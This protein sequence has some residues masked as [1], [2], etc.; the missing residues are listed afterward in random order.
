[1][2]NGSV[3]VTLAL[4]KEFK[5]SIRYNFTADDNNIENEFIEH[6][7][8]H[9]FGDITWYPSRHTAVYRYD[10]RVAISTPGDGVN[11]FIGFQSNLILVSKSDRA[12]GTFFFTYFSSFIYVHTTLYSCMYI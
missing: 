6:G 8:K 4:E 7:K 3:Q 1:M 12:A 2:N 10:D 5:R 9:E 11:D